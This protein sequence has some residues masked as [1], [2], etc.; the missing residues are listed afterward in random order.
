MKK[1]IIGVLLLNFLTFEPLVVWYFLKGL[2]VTEGYLMTMA[3]V[4]MCTTGFQ[5][6]MYCC[7]ILAGYK[8]IG[9]KTEH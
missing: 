1:I 2:N 5:G 9:V 4:G 3:L 7:L 6:F 8:E